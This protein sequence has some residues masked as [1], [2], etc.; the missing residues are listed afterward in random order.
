MSVKMAYRTVFLDLSLHFERGLVRHGSTSESLPP[1]PGSAT[2]QQQLR[3]L[4]PLTLTTTLTTD[5]SSYGGSEI[6]CR[7]AVEARLDFVRGRNVLPL[8]SLNHSGGYHQG[9][10]V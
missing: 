2:A 4:A 1:P 5:R 9:G 6:G 7:I 10:E 8:A 3:F